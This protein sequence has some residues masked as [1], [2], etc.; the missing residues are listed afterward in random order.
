MSEAIRR[1]KQDMQDMLAKTADWLLARVRET[2]RVALVLGS[3][4]GALAD[5]LQD[6]QTFPYEEIPGFPS[7]TVPGHSGTLIFGRLGDVPVVTM[8]GRFHHYE[9]HDMATVVFPLRVFARMGVRNLFLTNAAGGVNLQY[10]P[11]DLMVLS[12][13]V[14]L[15]AESPLRGPNPDELGPRFPDMSGVY[16][17]A[18]ARLATQTAARDGFSLQQGVYAYCRGPAFETPAE[19]R[20]L[21][22]LGADA[23][24]MST[25]PE[26]V[27]ARHMG[28][29]VLAISC[30]TNMAAGVLD[31]PLSH[32]E[33]METG[34]MVEKRFSALVTGIVSSWPIAE[35]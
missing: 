1:D 12:D 10:K 27:A 33:V 21:R 23:V 30:I 25:V 15:W 4:L 8:K 13:H 7:T 31:Q 17:P 28:M 11:G 20:A 29:R 24:G 9:G 6:R 34:R 32:E 19:I 26:A 16:D 22:I 3:G 35:G 5:T 14:G 18:L 2:P